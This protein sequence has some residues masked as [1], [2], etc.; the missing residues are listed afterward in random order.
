[1]EYCYRSLIPEEHISIIE[2]EQFSDHD[3]VQKIKVII[4]D[5]EKNVLV[6]RSIDKKKDE[7]T[8][9]MPKIHKF[10]LICLKNHDNN[11]SRH[12]DVSIF[13]RFKDEFYEKKEF[14]YNN[15]DKFILKDD[16]D[17]ISKE[18]HKFKHKVTYLSTL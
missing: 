7:I 5:W 8:L 4:T 17:N 10:H 15:K 16:Y 14:Y 18:S 2:Y 6:S 11:N 1:M 12:D 3:E 13:F 9:P